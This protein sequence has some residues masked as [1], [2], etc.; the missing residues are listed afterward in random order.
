MNARRFVIDVTDSDS[1]SFDS[2]S[3]LRSILH[4][5]L[6][7]WTPLPI[8]SLKFIDDLNA[9][10][11]CDITDCTTTV[12]VKKEKRFLHAR[13]LEDYF[14]NVR[15]EAAATGMR[16]NPSKTQLLCTN[17]SINYDIRAY[18]KID[19][20]T[21]WSGDTL[22]TV[23][24]TLGRRAGAAEHIKSMR[25][26]FG[27]RAGILRHLKKIGI[28]NDTLV[29][30]YASLIRPVLEYA[31]AC[32]H[33]GLTGDQSERLQRVS[34]KIIFGLTTPYEDCLRFS[35]LELLSTRARCVSVPPT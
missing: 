23:G 35:G 18:V 17:T 29:K 1:D 22:K 20:T 25:R 28:Q 34:L 6:D 21:L 30:I 7:R 9:H 10:E 15:R 19:G 14:E 27:A 33:P 3:Q 11:K 12:T 13:Q 32:F 5:P 24:Y 26:K 16:V 4:S 31:A 2:G 8:K